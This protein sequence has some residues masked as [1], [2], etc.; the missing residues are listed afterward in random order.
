ME[1]R[2][3]SPSETVQDL[4]KEIDGLKTRVRSVEIE[5]VQMSRSVQQ[6]Q[7]SMAHLQPQVRRLSQND[8]V[9]QHQIGRL[10]GLMPTFGL[11]ALRKWLG[12][13]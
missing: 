12:R 5:F 3:R 4:R 1:N 11:S 9:L 2:H 6:L 8:A 10:R 13:S 7:R